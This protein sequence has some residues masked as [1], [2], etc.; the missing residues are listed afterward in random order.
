VRNNSNRENR[1]IVPVTLRGPNKGR[2]GGVTLKSVRILKPKLW[3]ASP[4]SS[5]SPTSIAQGVKSEWWSTSDVCLK[6]VINF[7]HRTYTDFLFR[8]LAVQ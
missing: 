1:G 8:E 2:V 3:D 7:F 5:K 6:Y 4:G